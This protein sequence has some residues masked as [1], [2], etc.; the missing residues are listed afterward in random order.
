M[1]RDAGLPRV[2]GRL[3]AEA[4]AVGLL[5]LALFVEVALLSYVQSDPWWGFGER[6]ANRCGPVGAAVAGVLAGSFGWAAHVLPVAAAWIALRYLRG[7]P[8]RP[9][10]IPIAAWGGFWMA[11]AGSLEALRNSF[12]DALPAGAGGLLGSVL[13]EGLSGAFYL[14][15]THLILG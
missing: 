7:L 13:V 14:A 10:W 12:P 15:G 9:R 11:L 6:V 1:A 3:E 2:P 5:A 4:V 8:M